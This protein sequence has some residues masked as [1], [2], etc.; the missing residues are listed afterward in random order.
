VAA[1]LVLLCLDP[2]RA[3][4]GPIKLVSPGTGWVAH[5]KNLYWTN[6]NGNHWSDI[7]P[8]LP[9]IPRAGVAASARFFRDKSEGWEVIS[10]PEQV[11]PTTPPSPGSEKTVYSI[12]HS[13]N[14]GASWSFTPLTYPELPEWIQDTFAGPTDLY[15]ADSLHGWL[16]IAFAGNSKPGKLLATEDGGKTWNWVNG[17]GFSGPI[18]FA[19]LRDGWV[20]GYFGGE[21]LFVTHDGCKT[22]QEVNVPLPPQVGAAISPTF[23]GP[24]VFQ[25]DRKGFLVVH[26]SGKPGTPTKLVI[27]ST[28]DTGYTWQPIKVMTEAREA[29]ASATFVFSVVDS[30]LIVSTGSSASDVAVAPVPLANGGS[31]DVTASDRGVLALTFADLANGWAMTADD[32]LLATGDGGSTWK[33]ITPWRVVAS[34]AAKTFPIAEAPAMDVS[35]SSGFKA[36]AVGVGGS[37]PFKQTSRVRHI[38]FRTV[39]RLPCARD[40]ECGTLLP[41][42]HYS[43]RVR[44]RRSRMPDRRAWHRRRTVD[45]TGSHRLFF[46]EIRSA[47]V[48]A[49]ISGSLR[50]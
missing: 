33:D 24:P 28:L 47:I 49:G 48:R 18:T 46:S 34:P 40:R 45:S 4:A 7:T 22:W 8:V 13:T 39:S 38:P 31:S 37:A 12:A 19:S 2:V 3:T 9:G 29:T 21:R 42:D 43:I 30:S 23:Q 26:Y 6:D 36:L 50:C 44:E 10:Y 41:P 35:N 25:D 15:F 17:P 14:S 5:G 16:N 11:P 27:Y 20:A 1:L 32:R